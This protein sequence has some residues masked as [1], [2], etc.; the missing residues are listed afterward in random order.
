MMGSCLVEDMGRRML[1]RCHVGIDDDPG[2]DRRG[3]LVLEVVEKVVGRKG[4]G[5]EEV[6]RRWDREVERI[7]VID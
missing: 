4:Y 6:V 7:V 2:L 1:E 5:F 3:I